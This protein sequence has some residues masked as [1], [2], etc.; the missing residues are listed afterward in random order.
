M[1]KLMALLALLFVAGWTTG[2]IGAPMAADGRRQAIAAPAKHIVCRGGAKRALIGGHLRCLSVGQRCD[3]SFNTTKPSYRRYRFLC[4]SWYTS[5][6]TTLFRIAQPAAAPTTCSGIRPTPSSAHP[7]SSK[8]PW[9]GDSP[10][11]LGPYLDWRSST[12]SGIWRYFFATGLRDRSGWGVKFVWQLLDSAGPT[13]VSF[14]DMATGKSVP[15]I[16]AGVY[17]ERSTSPLLD[18]ARP[19]HQDPFG[20]HPGASEWGSTV[21]FP[22]AGCYRLDAQ[23]AD[24]LTMIVFS[25]GR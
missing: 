18:P 25:F 14:T 7:G 2:A 19:G 13:R 8:S 10:L 1:T 17:V 23:W 11:W 4:S 6:P 20:Q 21:L 9:I 15:V 5:A 24:G 12:A 16:L 3:I 22:A